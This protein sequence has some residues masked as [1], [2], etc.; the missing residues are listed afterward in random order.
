M[1]PV[2][3]GLWR[4]LQP[5]G[6]A[7][8]VQSRVRAAWVPV[9]FGAVLLAAAFLRGWGLAAKSLWF[10]EAYSVFVAQQPLTQIPRLLRNFDTH[11]P[12]HYMLLNVWM[13]F[14]G[15]SEAAVRLPSLLASLGVIALTF[16]LGRRLNGNRVGILA[17]AFVALSPFQIT[18]AQEARMYPFLTLFGLGATYA[19]WLALEEGRPRHWIAYA[20]LLLLA[21]Y[22]HHFAFLLIPAH[23]A[24]LVAA[25]PGRPAMRAWLLA[26]AGVV[27]GYLPLLPALAAQFGTA[28]NWPNIRPPFGLGAL[29]DTLGLLSFGGGILGMGTYFH[30]GVLALGERVPIL[31]PFMLL[32]MAG[33]IGLRGRGRIFTLTY[34][35]VPLLV[36]SAVSLRWNIFYERYFSFVL[37]PFAILLAAGVFALTDAVRPLRRTAVLAGAVALVFSFI[38]PSLANVYRAPTMYDWRG[39]ARYV[40][41]N[42][43][44]DD[45]I[46]FIPAFARIPFEYYFSGSQPRRGVNPRELLTAEQ[47]AAAGRIQVQNAM[48]P[49]EMARLA[50]GHPRLW[51]VATIPIGYEAR[52]RIG[53]VLSPS[54]REV[55]GKIFGQAVFTFLWES[56]FYPG[57]LGRW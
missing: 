24:Y 52:V 18:S 51:I 3:A 57:P 20:V 10:D 41:S 35:L 40:T 8:V 53:K 50:R 29:T 47:L 21:L 39:A 30:R 11:P 48:P 2:E 31:L 6:L 44:K 9:A 43:R 37:P 25:R 16:L 54:F 55:E 19:L 34:W 36:V 56:R 49:R 26:M 38:L 27:A 1:R 7:A 23:G 33:A 5:V 32:A 15:R 13:A 42:A 17:A 22:S 45:F 46:M 14:F 4:R 28:R 12:L